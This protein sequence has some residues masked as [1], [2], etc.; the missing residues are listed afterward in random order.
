M[1]ASIRDFTSDDYPACVRI[2]NAVYPDHVETEED[3]RYYDE[4]RESKTRFRR[5]VAVKDA[6]VVGWAQYDQHPWMYHPRKYYFHAQVLPPND[7]QGIGSALF[8]TVGKTLADRDAL[9]MRTSA[10]ESHPE[11][12]TF[13]KN[14]GFVE[15]R[16]G[17]ESELDLAKFD[18]SP[19]AGTIDKVRGQGI[20]IITF[21]E[22]AAED[23]DWKRRLHVLEVECG[24]DVPR[25][26]EYT[27][28]SF[29][30]YEKE[31]LGDPRYLPDG[32]FVAVDGVN[33]VGMSQLWA[34]RGEA[35]LGI[36][37]TGVLREYR[38]RGI[39]TALKLKGIE[40]ARARGAPAITTGNDTLN[41]PIL[42]INV[43]MGFKRKPVWVHMAK[44]LKEG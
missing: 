11:A 9:M 24:R 19:F 25:P 7:R 33:L 1:D 34:S 38:G 17:W 20:R 15:E 42:A 12:L 43:K 22:L 32:A 6:D 18:A 2:T 14:R 4:H 8:E 37:L 23:T 13:L 21:A 5:W 41:A 3:W 30:F 44:A 40:Y 26:D 27:P 28:I 35:K 10:R 36:G 39:A 29:E 16:R 31:V